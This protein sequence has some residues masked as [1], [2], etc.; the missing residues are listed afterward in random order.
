MD[1]SASYDYDAG[2]L[3]AWNTG[4]TGNYVIDNKSLTNPGTPV[5]SMYSSIQNGT[6]NSGGR[7]RYRARLGWAGGPDSAFTIT[8]FMN[9]LPSFN[10][11]GGALAPLCFLGGNTPCNAGGT[12]QFAMYDTQVPTLSNFVPSMYTFDLSLGYRTG[13]LPENAY[14]KNIALTV[15]VND[16]TNR[17]PPFQYSVA[18]SSNTPHAFYNEISADQRFIT[19]TLSKAW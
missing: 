16:L 1:F 6:R 8:G 15:T 11:N 7:L 2:D 13:D 12:P 19:I 4:I 3:G 14:L 17:K 5:V 9:Y 10:V 18:T